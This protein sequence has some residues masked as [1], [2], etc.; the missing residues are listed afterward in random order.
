[1]R[2]VPTS[3]PSRRG[4]IFDVDGTLADTNYLHIV[5]WW[6]A[7]R[8]AGHEVV[9]SDLHALIG[10]GADQLL[11]RLVGSED[12]AIKRSHTRFYSPYLDSLRRFPKADE[13]LKACAGLGLEIVLATSAPKEEVAALREALDADDVISEVTSSED[14]EMSKPAPELLEVTLGKTGARLEVVQQLRRVAVNRDGAGFAQ[15]RTVDAAAQYADAGDACL[16]GSLH[17]PGGVADHDAVGGLQRYR[18]AG[19]PPA[20]GQCMTRRMSG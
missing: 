1:M 15:P 12:A 10:M 6:Q 3:Q 11:P 2:G 13:L 20:I 8:T 17:V 4:V 18:R 14:V 5:A 19:A 9:M 7:F 16:A